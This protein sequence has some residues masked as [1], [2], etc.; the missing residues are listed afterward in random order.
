LLPDNLFCR[1][2]RS[3]LINT[4]QI[5]KLAGD[6]TNQVLMNNGLQIPISRRR[7]S[8]LIEFLEVN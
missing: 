1:I 3:Y 7:Y 6:S 5:K 4:K 8:S 2:H